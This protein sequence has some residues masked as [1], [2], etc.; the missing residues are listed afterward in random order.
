MHYNKLSPSKI[1]KLEP[2]ERQY[3]KADGMGLTMI[4]HPNG[5]KYWRFRYR[6]MGIQKMIGCGT[7]PAVAVTEA[8]EKRDEYRALLKVGKDPAEV[9]DQQR[10]QMDASR[11]AEYAEAWVGKFLKNKTAKTRNQ[12]TGRLVKWVYPRIGKYPIPAITRQ[13]LIPV[14]RS[15]EDAGGYRNGPASPQSARSDI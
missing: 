4:V 14:L 9:R 13:T 12:A 8:R 11:F 3:T 10:Y 15:I 5:G 6:F 1:A 7:Y 2:R